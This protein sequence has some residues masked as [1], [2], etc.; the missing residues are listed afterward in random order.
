MAYNQVHT[1]KELPSVQITHQDSHQPQQ[2]QHQQHQQHQQ[3][4]Q[5]QPN[6]T[7]DRLKLLRNIL[8]DHRDASIA[9]DELSDP[10]GMVEKPPPLPPAKVTAE[11]DILEDDLFEHGF[12]E[13]LNAMEFSLDSEDV[14]NTELEKLVKLDRNISQ[15][16]AIV[17]ELLQYL[18]N[19]ESNLSNLSAQMNNLKTQSEQLNHQLTSSSKLE[20][21]LTPIVTDFIVSPDIVNSV[22][23][24]KIN[25]QWCDNLSYINL[26]IELYNKYQKEIKESLDGG[27]NNNKDQDIDPRNLAKFLDE[28]KHLVDLLICKVVEKIKDFFVNK[29]KLIRY[30]KNFTLQVLQKNLLTMKEIFLFLLTHNKPLALDLQQAYILTVKWYYFK[31]FGKYLYSLE[32]LKLY[33]IDKAYMLGNMHQEFANSSGLTASAAATSRSASWLSPFSYSN[34]NAGYG[35]SSPGNT[36]ANKKSETVLLQDYFSV[37]NRLDILTQDDPT[38]LPAQIAETNPLTYWLETPFRSFNLALIDNGTVEYLFLSEFFQIKNPEE[39]SKIFQEIFQNVFQIGINFTKTYL[40]N[41]INHD[42]FTILICIKLCQVMLFKLQHRKIPVMENYFNLQVITLWPKYQLIIDANCANLKK[43]LIKTTAAASNSYF[44]SFNSSNTKDNNSLLRQSTHQRSG[45]L[46]ISSGHASDGSLVP[47]PVTQQFATLL[48]SLLKIAAIDTSNPSLISDINQRAAFQS[49]AATPLANQ[50]I[51]SK[52]HQKAGLSGSDATTTLTT[53]TNSNTNTTTSANGT[54]STSR[55]AANADDN[56]SIYDNSA[57]GISNIAQKVPELQQTEPLSTSIVRLRNEF[58]NVLNK[59]SIRAAGSGSGGGSGNAGS[60][61]KRET[62]L[63][64]NYFLLYTV[65][66]QCEGQVAE[67]EKEHFKMLMDAYSQSLG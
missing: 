56:S 23:K 7:V 14:Y 24:D 20:E 28:M 33:N 15:S 29:I 18:T 31:N 65:T 3:Q 50:F 63:Y 21:K 25:V 35:A 36:A 40:T 51:I 39:L 26:K 66:Q 22:L 8:G 59:L 48:A 43:V 27:S 60:S 41:A 30:S 34:K 2:Q 45:S 11:S 9:K 57:Q 4:Q 52:A 17:L 44:S 67:A 32:K 37:N 16:R 42:F 19:F 13:T 53:T 47:H 38:V 5:K 1:Q 10:N 64:N 49:R 62:F 58:E 61:K 54:P 12:F 46:G 6:S 55:T